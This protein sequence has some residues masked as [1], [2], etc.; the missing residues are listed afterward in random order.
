MFQ[1]R[2][3]ADTTPADRLFSMLWSAGYGR[4]GIE[5]AVRAV[6]DTR[7]ARDNPADFVEA[8]EAYAQRVAN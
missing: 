4:G 5:S 2:N 8:L 3:S 7:L 6:A 1:T